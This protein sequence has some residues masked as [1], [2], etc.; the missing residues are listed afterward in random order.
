M[1]PS[2]STLIMLPAMI[3]VVP[4]KNEL[5]RYEAAIVDYDKALNINPKLC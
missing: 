3:L 5:G 4:P 2:V 1:N